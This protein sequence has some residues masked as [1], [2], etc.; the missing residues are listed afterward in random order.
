MPLQKG[1]VINSRYRIVRH[2]GGGGF[3]N[4]Y[5]AW[6]LALNHPVALKENT[7]AS[8]ESREQ[9]LFEAAT[10]A[11]L[12]HA[13]LPRVTDHF[14]LPNQGQ[15]LVMDYIEGDN[16]E[17]LLQQQQ[18][19]FALAEIKPWIEQVCTAVSYLHDCDPVIIHRDI[20]PANIVIDKNG[21]AILVDFGIAKAETVAG[22]PTLKGAKAVSPGYSPPE[23]YRGHTGVFSDV[24]SLG[25]TVYHLL[26]NAT[27]SIG[28]D[29]QI[30][31]YQL[32]PPSQVVNAIEDRIDRVL[33]KALSTQPDQRFET[34]EAFCEA[35]FDSTPT[36]VDAGSGGGL[37]KWMLAV[38]GVVAVVLAIG[39]YLVLAGDETACTPPDLV[40]RVSSVA[41]DSRLSVDRVS[42]SDQVSVLAGDPIHISM[43][44]EDDAERALSCQWQ[45]TSGNVIAEN[46]CEVEFE[47]DSTTA[48]IQSRVS[49]AG[50][51]DSSY[52]KSLTIRPTP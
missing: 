11:G 35:L 4:I 1:Y 47:P 42:G 10:L 17:L 37:K 39:A 38:A 33:V 14:I 13:N 49:L 28:T 24:Y 25:A 46:Q 21:N 36:V 40:W 15:F 6:D 43:R 48:I 23:Q 12:R 3:G 51:G 5:R 44:D 32:L 45:A 22:K 16:L 31:N 2:I 26:T 34:V 20:K 18:R 41:T 52:T 27:I 50:C 29:S 7:A 19:P 30:H 9:F 8:A